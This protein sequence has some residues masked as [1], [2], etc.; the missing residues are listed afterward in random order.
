MS[1]K[2]DWNAIG[3]DF[4]DPDKGEILKIAKLISMGLQISVENLWPV[5]QQDLY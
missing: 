4:T 1:E 3:A 2:N 5:L